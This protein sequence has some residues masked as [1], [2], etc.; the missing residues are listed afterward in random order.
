MECYVIL[1]IYAGELELAGIFMLTNVN[2]LQLKHVINCHI[3]EC[4]ISI[5]STPASGHHLLNLASYITGLYSACLLLPT[6]LP[7]A[8]ELCVN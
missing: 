3:A 5:L 6:L 7:V 2:K 1:N 8:I 4:V